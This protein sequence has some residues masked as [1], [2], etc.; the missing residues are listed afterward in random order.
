MSSVLFHQIQP[1]S[2]QLQWLPSRKKDLS[3]SYNC[4]IHLGPIRLLSLP[5]KKKELSGRHF[6]N[7]DV[8]TTVDHLLEVQDTDFCKE[9]IHMLHD[10]WSKCL[11]V[12]DYVEKKT[13]TLSVTPDILSSSIHWIYRQ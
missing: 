10:L 2:P 4:P 8:I 1:K 7:N 12:K 11:N 3:S 9:E 5:L 6:E 13:E